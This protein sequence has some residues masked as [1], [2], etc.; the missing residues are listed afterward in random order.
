MIRYQSLHS[1][2]MLRV[3]GNFPEK[4]VF[5]DNESEASRRMQEADDWEL[6]AQAQAG[7]MEAFTALV[8]RYQAPVMHFCRRM[9]GSP[10]DAE[11]VAQECFVR[12]HR[13]L[14]RLQPRARFSTMLFGIARNLALNAVRDAARRPAP[15][16][17]EAMDRPVADPA[18]S[19]A[20]RAQVREIESAL[21]RGLAMLSPEH[22]EVLL[23][24][25]FQGMDYE[26]MAKVLRCRKGTVR[27]R[28]AR[29]REQLRE[30]L[31]VLGGDLL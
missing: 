1:V 19:P 15:A 21:E 31:F 3:L 7:D 18:F 26:T 8:R 30:Y 12:L 6:V 23:L 2:R 11:E 10:Q 24:R 22:R 28:L 16:P 20:R 4:T 14:R 25:E 29:A 17:A 27:S 5:N 13:H 9:V